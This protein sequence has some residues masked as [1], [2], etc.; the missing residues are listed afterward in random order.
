MQHDGDWVYVF[1]VKAGRHEGPMILRRV[2]WDKMAD[3]TAHQDW[4]WNGQDWGWYGP[5]SP[6]SRER[7]ES[8]GAVGS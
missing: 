4:D 8:F 2:P 5:C 6:F 3:Q 7:S 1:S